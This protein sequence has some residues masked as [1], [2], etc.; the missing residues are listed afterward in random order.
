M[1]D[2]WA[3][4][5]PQFLASLA[6]AVVGLVGVIIA[7]RLERGASR[8]D[9]VDAAVE[10][11]LV[12]LSTFVSKMATWRDAGDRPVASPRAY[13]FAV[14][15]A[16]EILVMRTRKDSRKIAQEFARL[17]GDIAPAANLEAQETA[18][19]LLA[20]AITAWRAGLGDAEVE[21]RLE[22]IREL[23]N[24]EVLDPPD[25]TDD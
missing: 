20:S 23:V 5:V 8:A 10:R 13:P 6:G 2:F 15:I 18:S 7:F 24:G 1:E 14:S 17:W 3:S 9:S 12:E 11:V 16:L 19:G 22:R 4:F 21:E 25:D